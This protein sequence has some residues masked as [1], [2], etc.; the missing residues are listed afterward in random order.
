MSIYLDVS[1]LDSAIL[2]ISPTL[3][4]SRLPPTSD[5]LF[6][7]ILGLPSTTSSSLSK[8]TKAYQ[9]KI[10]PVAFRSTTPVSASDIFDELVGLASPVKAKST[11][12]EEGLYVVSIKVPTVDEKRGME[13]LN[14]V[15]GVLEGSSS[16]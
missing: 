4:K 13:F 9:A 10:S 7:E 5:E 14:G 8:P 11:K 15:K 2:A 12:Q 1:K 16:T 6:D 3:S